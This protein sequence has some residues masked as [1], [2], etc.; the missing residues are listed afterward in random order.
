MAGSFI[1]IDGC[2]SY[3][4][5]TVAN[6]VNTVTFGKIVNIG[7]VKDTSAFTY[8]LYA[9]D[10]GLTY[11]IGHVASST[12]IIDADTDTTLSMVTVGGA[13]YLKVEAVDTTAV[14]Y[15]TR[16]KITF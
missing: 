2:S 16:Y 9:L 13:S 7:W 5:S 6:L 4:E 1:D 12:L 3:Q 8:E 15:E 11:K 14:G 10:S